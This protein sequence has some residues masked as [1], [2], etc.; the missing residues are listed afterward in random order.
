MKANDYSRLIPRKRRD[1]PVSYKRTTGVAQQ[2]TPE[3]AT[4]ITA[5]TASIQIPGL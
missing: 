5:T 3:K 2:R 1:L 4:V